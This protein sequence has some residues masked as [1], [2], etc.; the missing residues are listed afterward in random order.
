[1]QPQMAGDLLHPCFG[2][3]GR[4]G[5]AATHILQEFTCIH[6]AGESVARRRPR[7]FSDLFLSQTNDS[8]TRL[9]HIW[10][11]YIYIEICRNILR[12][13]EARHQRSPEVTKQVTLSQRSPMSSHRWFQAGCRSLE[14]LRARQ[15]ELQLTRT[16]RRRPMLGVWWPMVTYNQ[17]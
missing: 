5:D 3:P 8:M 17:V 13:C 9:E 16:Q 6:G 4:S 7:N 2:N 10:T 14:D 15:D 11:Y 12:S 1:M